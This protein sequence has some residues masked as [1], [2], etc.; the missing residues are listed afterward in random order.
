MLPFTGP[1]EKLNENIQH[2]RANS[3]FC[4]EIC[5]TVGNIIHNTTSV[6]IYLPLHLVLFT[7]SL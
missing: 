5:L 3:N 6:N 1:E 2:L 4:L 7:V